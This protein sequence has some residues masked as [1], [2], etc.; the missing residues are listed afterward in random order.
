LVKTAGG[1]IVMPAASAIA[2]IRVQMVLRVSGL[3]SRRNWLDGIPSAGH[4]GWI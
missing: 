4:S 2:P 3:I 1:F